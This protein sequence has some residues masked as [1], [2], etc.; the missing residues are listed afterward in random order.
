MLRVSK[1]M[2]TFACGL[3]G[4]LKKTSNRTVCNAHQVIIMKTR[5]ITIV[6]IDCCASASVIL[7]T[8]L[9]ASAPFDKRTFFH[10]IAYY[11]RFQ[12]KW[13]S[14]FTPN[15]L[16]FLNINKAFSPYFSFSSF[17]TRKNSR[18]LCCFRD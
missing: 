13:I 5:L 12:Y 17:H 7:S 16:F 18:F 4:F 14:Y 10:L 8:P 9:S 11:K 15:Q 2:R 6:K 3:F 1:I